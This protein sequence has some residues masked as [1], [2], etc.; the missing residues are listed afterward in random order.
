MSA[1]YKLIGGLVGNVVAM[2]LVYL[3]LKGVATCSPGVN[4]VPSC[5]IA[6]L[7]DVQITVIIMTLLNA[8]GIHQAPANTAPTP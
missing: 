4:A 7:S 3:S 2:I 6:G 1:Y 5:T 8:I